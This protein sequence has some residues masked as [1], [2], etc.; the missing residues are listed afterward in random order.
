[1][2]R[3]GQ[4]AF[5][6]HQGRVQIYIDDPMLTLGGS[7]EERALALAICLLPRLALGFRISWKKAARGPGLQWLGLCFCIDM[8]GRAVGVSMPRQQIAEIRALVESALAKPM[9][10][11]KCLSK[12]AG[13]TS[14]IACVVPGTRW[15]AQRFYAA[16][17][18]GLESTSKPRSGGRSFALIHWCRVDT[19]LRWVLAFL[20]ARGGPPVCV[21][22]AV[23][24]IS[25]RAGV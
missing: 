24:P 16:L 18:D 14:W 20:D 23:A 10:P 3:A 12:L 11:V 8:L 9:V 1:M 22:E 13:K 7:A 5:R 25:V 19:L 17:A 21:W 15:T 4:A 6:V 2:G